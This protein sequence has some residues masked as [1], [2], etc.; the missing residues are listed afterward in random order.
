MCDLLEDYPEKLTEFLNE[1]SLE[2]SCLKPYLYFY[3]RVVYQLR[4]A[5]NNKTLIK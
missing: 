4:K 3:K 2:S 5:N 1:S